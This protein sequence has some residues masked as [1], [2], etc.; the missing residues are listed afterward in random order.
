MLARRVAGGS[1]EAAGRSVS[2]AFCR[3]SEF[4]FCARGLPGRAGTPMPLRRN[5]DAVAPERPPRLAGTAA[6]AERMRLSRPVPCLW[7]SRSPRLCVECRRPPR[8]LW[9]LLYII[10]HTREPTPCGEARGMETCPG[11]APF[12]GLP[13]AN[14][15]FWGDSGVF[16]VP[17]SPGIWYHIGSNQG[18]KRCP[19][20]LILCPSA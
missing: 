18:D 13:A 9:K 5:G 3:P 4:A 20:V 12:S 11:C 14:L 6:G 15:K 19:R 2:V 1:C 10:R 7:A 8:S 17:F 16:S